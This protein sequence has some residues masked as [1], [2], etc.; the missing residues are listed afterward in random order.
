V[1][2]LATYPLPGDIQT[3]VIYQNVPG[4][5]IVATFNASNANVRTTLGRDLTACTGS[6]GACSQTVTVQLLPVALLGAVGSGAQLYEDRLS[7]V[8]LRFART[9][10]L[11]GTQRL[12][13]SVDVLNLLNTSSVLRSNGVIGGSTPWLTVL[14]ILTGRLIKVSAQFDF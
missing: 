9:F 13:G 7:Q 4:N 10:R 3:S 2:F 5:P 12:K 14:Q 1:K 6:V 11:A 8:D